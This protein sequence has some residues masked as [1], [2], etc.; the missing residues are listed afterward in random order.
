MGTKP[1]LTALAISA[2]FSI[3]SAQAADEQLTASSGANDQDIEKIV[4]IGRSEQTPINMAANV[5]VIDAAEIEMSG[6]TT[7]ESLLRNQAGIQIS[8]SNSGPVFSMRGFGSSGAANNTLILVD[9]RR[10]NNIDISAPTIGAIPVNLIERVEV[11]SGSAGVLYGDQAVGG[12]INI[13]TR[14]PQASGGGI[15]LSGGSFNT[16]EAKGDIAG[17]INDNWRYFLAGSQK[18]SDNYRKNNESKTASILGRLQYADD[19]QDFF[20]EANYYDN[21]RLLAGAIS[22]DEFNKDPRHSNNDSSKYTHEM[23][24]STRLGYVRQ[25]SEQWAID[26]GVSY[27]DTLTTSFNWSASRNKRSQFAFLPKAVGTYQLDQGEMTIVAGADILSGKADFSSM[28][29]SNTQT[30]LSGYVH[31]TVPLTSSVSY[32][33]GGRYAKAKDD[34][35]DQA[36]YPA[37]VDLDQSA[38]AFELGL[39]YRPTESQRLYVRAD[40]NFR[41]AKVDEQA[42]TPKGVVGLKPQ[43]GRSYEA[44]WDFASGANAI[45]INAYRLDLEDEIIFDP[46]AEKPEGGNFNGANVNAEASRRYGV[47]AKYEVSFAK[48]WLWGIEYNYIDAEFTEGVNKGKKLSWVAEHSGRSFINYDITDNLQTFLEA[49]YTGDRFMQGDNANVGNKIDS[50]LLTNLAVNYNRGDWKASLRV[51]NL[52]DKQYVSSGYFSTWGNGYYS[53]TGREIR[54]TAGYR[55]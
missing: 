32:V 20:V 11:L 28:G 30:Q 31:A 10:L 27:T 40:D 37:G 38:H 24:N 43:V 25:L 14:A 53:G 5:T 18:N 4:V 47:H 19:V 15:E 26:T 16:L 13:V 36:V 8:D 41:F 39:N 49:S 45:S 6:A 34:L 33:V 17:E 22:E 21:H 55:F 46:S 51:D 12:V 23:T 29:R 1:T 2:F 7:I 50:Y 9:G 52:F 54:L 44:G 42:Y 35:V 48:A 3:S